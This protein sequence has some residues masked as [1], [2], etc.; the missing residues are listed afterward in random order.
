MILCILAYYV[1]DCLRCLFLV[2]SIFTLRIFGWIYILFAANELLLMAVIIG[3]PVVRLSYEGQVC[4]GEVPRFF[5]EANLPVQG[6]YLYRMIYL[7]P[8]YSVGI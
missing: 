8:I 6:R 1:T 3:V 7:I 2:L 5:F 4:S